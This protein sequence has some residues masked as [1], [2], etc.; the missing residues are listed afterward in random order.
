MTDK[1]TETRKNIFALFRLRLQQLKTCS[2]KKPQTARSAS[3][4]RCEEDPEGCVRT[5]SGSAE[6]GWSRGQRVR[7][8]PASV[9]WP[10]DGGSA[11]SS[12]HE[13]TETC[14]QVGW[15]RDRGDARRPRWPPL[16]RAAPFLL[17]SN[18]KK[19]SSCVRGHPAHAAWRHS[20]NGRSDVCSSY[21]WPFLSFCVRVVSLQLK[22]GCE[23]SEE[24]LSSPSAHQLLFP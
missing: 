10:A 9:A 21:S 6:R 12:E 5:K 17:H 3:D 24:N 20:V 13:L 7:S 4:S 16:H 23:S 1:W 8:T 18:K 19:K 14:Q 11:R 22:T 15:E 2:W